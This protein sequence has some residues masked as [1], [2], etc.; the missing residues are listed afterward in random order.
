MTG[1]CCGRRVWPFPVSNICNTSNSR[2]GL[3]ST[4]LHHHNPPSSTPALFLFSAVADMDHVSKTVIEAGKS[5]HIVVPKDGTDTSLTADFI[6]SIIGNDNLHPWTDVGGHLMSWS[7]EA[8]P[9]DVP[10]LELHKDIARVSKLELPAHKESKPQED[11]RLAVGKYAIYPIDG[12]NFEECNTT[13]A[14]LKAL[15]NDQVGDL[16][17]IDGRVRRWVGFMT[18]DQVRQVKGLGGVEAVSR[19]HRGRRCRVVRKD[20][21]SS[22]PPKPLRALASRDISYTTQENAV[23]ELVAISQPR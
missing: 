14:A 2:S 17:V 21:R 10:K 23:S 19:A 11:G 7:V 1:S 3:D 12:T 6:K 16:W 15:L 5:L 13:D 18:S 4:Q 22:T 9:S 8:S 20:Q